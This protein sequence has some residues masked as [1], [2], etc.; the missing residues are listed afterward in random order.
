[1]YP[2]NSNAMMSK[3]TAAGP[4][5][6]ILLC[7]L[8]A[9][10][11]FLQRM[12]YIDAYYWAMLFVIVASLPYIA[13][14]VTGRFILYESIYLFLGSFVLA[15]TAALFL[16][17]EY[18]DYDPDGLT[19]A[20]QYAIWGTIGFIIGY[21][22]RLGRVLANRLPIKNFTMSE[23]FL[24]RVPGKFYFLW[25]I[26]FLVTLFD[27]VRLPGSMIAMVDAIKNLLILVAIMIDSH[28]LF[29]KAEAEDK[30]KKRKCLFR[31]ILFSGLYL[32]QSF[33]SGFAGEM[34]VLF[35]VIFLVYIKAKKRVPVF[36][37]IALALTAF[38]FFAYVAPFTKAFRNYYW[39][40]MSLSESIDLASQSMSE[41]EYE[42]STV[43][44]VKRFSAPLEMTVLTSQLWE[45]G[46]RFYL[47]RDLTAFIARFIPRFMWP[48]KPASFDWN[49]IGRDLGI[50]DRN[51]FYTAVAL[52]LLSGFIIGGG[53][54]SVFIGMILV[55]VVIRTLWEWLIVRSKDN[56][57][58]LSIYLILLYM[59]MFGGNEFGSMLVCSVMFAAYA[60]I[61]LG[62]IRS[63]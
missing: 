47:Y 28:I 23:T 6:F 12:A 1:M 3:K 8:A 4:A 60:Y 14:L 34:A 54:M 52:P 25:L 21:R 46:R 36:S 55:G 35:I 18:I 42:T 44:S 48:N 51:D 11:F 40:G 5:F 19:A 53:A 22:L 43:E 56:F 7:H 30:T 15:H 57:L 49:K 61:F 39:K 31:I 24:Y 17:L 41:K 63:K 13:A 26:L 58:T 29:N 62:L 27:I 37:I 2:D 59:W 38:L 16:P 32:I 45:G 9:A 50:L 20:M 33:L 10:W